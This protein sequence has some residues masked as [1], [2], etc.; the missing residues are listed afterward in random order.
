M[1]VSKTGIGI[2]KFDELDSFFPAQDIL[3]KTGQ[4]VQFA[5]GVFGL[6][7]IPL[8]VKQNVEQIIRDEFAK[9]N[10][11][12]VLLPS[13]HP[14]ATWERSG[15][16]S[17]YVEDGTMLV[18][19]TGNGTFCLS[20]TA[21]EAIIEFAE[22]RLISHKQLPVILYQ[23]SDKY[24]NEIRNRGYMFRGKAFS[25][26]DAYSFDSSKEGLEKSYELVKEC[27]LNI[28]KKL[29]LNILPVAADTGSI[30]G[31][32]SEEFMLLSELGE[33]TILYNKDKNLALNTELL[34]L[35][36][37]EEVLRNEY[38]INSLEGFEKVKAI[39]L[40]TYIPIR[41]NIFRINEFAIYR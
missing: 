6:N 33:D 8:I 16:F 10:I 34:E 39:E 13:I 18:T 15:R 1:R 19:E 36:N 37:Y 20:P 22:Q 23:I 25:M 40:R 41:N 24:R 9:N 31:S 32:K 26:M 21:E 28:F 3:I 4:L 12:E 27:Y 7:H 14:K 17:K 5:S 2:A 35:E 11:I 30:G 29:G 38:N